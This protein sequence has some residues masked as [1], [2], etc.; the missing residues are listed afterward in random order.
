[1]RGEGGGMQ[2]S[3]SLPALPV[4][5]QAE[6]ALPEKTAKAKCGVRRKGGTGGSALPS[7]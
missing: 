5:A 4:S 3:A 7:L 1:M 6:G 2:Q